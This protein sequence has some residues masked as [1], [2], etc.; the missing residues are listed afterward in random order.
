MNETWITDTLHTQRQSQTWNILSWFRR[1]VSCFY[2]RLHIERRLTD[3]CS[4]SLYFRDSPTLPGPGA[5]IAG[6]AGAGSSNDSGPTAAQSG[7]APAT[8][9]PERK[10][11]PAG[12]ELGRGRTSPWQV[13][14]SRLPG[15]SGSLSRPVR[16][17]P[18]RKPEAL[19]LRRNRVV[20]VRNSHFKVLPDSARNSIGT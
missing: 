20:C 11:A 16:R 13:L 18:V 14:P 4:F 8:D 6:G 10:P 15:E 17:L 3:S 9:S 12:A 7:R 2:I 1:S 19:S 5:F